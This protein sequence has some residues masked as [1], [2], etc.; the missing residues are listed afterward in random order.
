MVERREFLRKIKYWEHG[1]DYGGK[2]LGATY[3]ERLGVYSHNTDKFSSVNQVTE[4]GYILED[5][6]MGVAFMQDVGF[7]KASK[8]AIRIDVERQLRAGWGGGADMIFK[9]W[10]SGGMLQ[11]S[12]TSKSSGKKIRKQPDHGLLM[13]V[14]AG[15]NKRIATSFHGGMVNDSRGWARYG[16]VVFKGRGED[17][18]LLVLL[19][20]YMPQTTGED[21]QWQEQALREQGI[22]TTAQQQTMIDIDA[23]L[24]EYRELGADVILFGDMNNIWDTHSYYGT[25][26]EKVKQ[27]G[28]HFAK[29]V[30]E[31]EYVNVARS[32]TPGLAPRTHS[33]ND[34]IGYDDKDMVLCREELLP[35]IVEYGSVDALRSEA[36]CTSRHYPIMV[37]INA[38]A[39]LHVKGDDVQRP[40]EYIDHSVLRATNEENSL[41]L[42]RMVD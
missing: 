22:E 15:W 2:G 6:G 36:V 38:K 3:D 9:I 28:P 1:T 25:V 31:N 8:G 16:G 24:L 32:R 40:R 13:A 35:Y 34:S 12:M 10:D 33:Y 21:S 30:A 19:Q 27:R 20:V 39:L 26:G 7:G 14:R 18:A 29:W 11:R 17:D 41:R 5:A 23:S 42:R 37:T 4:V